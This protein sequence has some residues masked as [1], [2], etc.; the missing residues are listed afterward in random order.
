MIEVSILQLLTYSGY[1][2]YRNRDQAKKIGNSYRSDPW[3]FRGQADIEVFVQGRVI[4]L[5]VKTPKGKSKLV[6]KLIRKQAEWRYAALFEAF[7]S[8]YPKHKLAGNAQYWLGESYYVTKNYE[9]AL[10]EAA[11]GVLRAEIAH[12]EEALLCHQHTKK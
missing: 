12:L 3:E 2:C 6:P 1:Y 8:N 9:I 11:I 10:E 7:L 4:F 5:E